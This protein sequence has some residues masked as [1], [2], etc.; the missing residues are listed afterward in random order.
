MTCFSHV[1]LTTSISVNRMAI[2]L[3]A[4]IRKYA[5]EEWVNKWPNS[6]TDI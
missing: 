5:G 1:V 4:N 6:M 3:E 2:K